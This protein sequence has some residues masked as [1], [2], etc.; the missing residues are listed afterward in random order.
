[1]DAWTY[2]GFVAGALTSTG[3]LP[4]L[5]KGYRTKR[6]EDVSLLMPLVLC[7]GMALWL[8]YGL[9]KQD[10]AIIAANVLGVTL[11]ALLV[12]MKM[13]YGRRTVQSAF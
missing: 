7:I 11:T 3:Y 2:I 12:L 6:L 1:M 10:L 13:H 8:V 5:F 9:A 4:Q